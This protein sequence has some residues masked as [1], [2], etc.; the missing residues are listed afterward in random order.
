MMPIAT[1]GTCSSRMARATTEESIV[2]GRAA[3][4]VRTRNAISTLCMV[5][6]YTATQGGRQSALQISG[7][8][9]CVLADSRKRRRT[10]F[11]SV[12][13]GE[14]EI[15]PIYPLKPAMRTDFLQSPAY[16][17]E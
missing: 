11:L 15:R 3:A 1:P 17:E 12:M 6:V 16:P 4:T 5:E 14:G 10:N 9:A 13:E 8:Q 2:A 7:C